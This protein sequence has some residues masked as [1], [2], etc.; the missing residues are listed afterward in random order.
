[1]SGG[2]SAPQPL[3]ADHRTEGFSCGEASLDEW[4]RRR[5]LVNQTTVV[6]RT[7]VVTDDQGQVL[8][9]YALAAGA[10]SHQESPG[11]IRRN[12][13]E[14]IPVMVLARLAVDQR[15]QGR[16][17]GGALLKDALRRAAAVAH[18][19]GVRALLVHALNEHA[20]QFYIHYGFMASPVNPMTLMLALHTKGAH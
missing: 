15:L 12:M 4:L 5:A 20:R 11:S 10:V 17:V 7:F 9:Y 18:N 19:V 6:S 8:A 13:P 16:Q 14:P 2:L 1:M 3:A